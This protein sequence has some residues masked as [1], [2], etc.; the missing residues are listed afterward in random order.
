MKSKPKLG[1]SLEYSYG[2]SLNNDPRILWYNYTS[3]LAIITKGE[4]LEYSQTLYLVNSIDLSSNNLSGSIPNSVVALV[5][6]ENLNLS[7]NN[8]N[9]KFLIRLAT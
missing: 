4:I 8:L 9:G 3:T 6:L 2:I 5:A 1:Y 7:R